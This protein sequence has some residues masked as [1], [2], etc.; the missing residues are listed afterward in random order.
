MRGVQRVAGLLLCASILFAAIG[1]APAQDEGFSQGQQT[2]VQED[3]QG[4][5]QMIYLYS[6]GVRMQLS[7]AENEATAALTR[8]LAQGDITYT[9]D[10]YG[11][12][13]KVGALGFSLPAQDARIQTQPGDVMLY[14]GDQ[15]VI[16]YGS[17]AWSYTPIGRLGDCTEQQLRQALAA[18][19]GEV[20]IRLSL[21]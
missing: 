9:A 6:N 5:L 18:G 11:G 10:D 19:A 12:F 3:G 14:Q 8:L 21:S 17:N 1:C 15:L 20:E 13:E 16:F 4:D 7:L 2:P